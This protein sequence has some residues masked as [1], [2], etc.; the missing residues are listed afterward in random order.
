MTDNSYTRPHHYT[1]D[2]VIGKSIKPKITDRE[3]ALLLTKKAIWLYFWLIIFEGALRKWFLPFLA[4]PLLIVRDP[5]ALWI[6]YSSIKN[7][8]FKINGMTSAVWF[9]GVVAVLLAIPFG[10]GSV[11][12][13]LFGGR[14]LFL[15]FPLIFITANLFNKADVIEIGK[16]TLWTSI[17]MTMI[18]V[19]QFYSPQSAWI[20]KGIGGEEVEG[21]SG[22]MGF[23]RPP[24]T[25]SFTNGLAAYY[26]LLAAFVFYFWL[27]NRASVKKSLLIIATVCLIIA[28]PMSIS[29]TLFFSVLLSGAFTVGIAVRKPQMLVR[30]AIAVV[31]IIILLLVVGNL[32]FFQTGVAAFTDRFAS[33]SD[34]QESG[35]A[36]TLI[37]RVLGGM[38]GALSGTS[39]IPFFGYGIGMGT[40]VGASLLTGKVSFL[41]SEGEWGRVIGEMGILLGLAFI[42]IRVKLGIT[43]AL[44]SFKAIKRSNY[45]PW[46][47]LS[48]S[49]LNLLQGQWAQPSAL[50]FAV[51]ASGITMAA[52]KEN[53]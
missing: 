24:G 12:V 35:V 23:S 2:T 41:I 15:H 29:R 9:L 3:K 39:N 43:I 38:V 16:A 7:N 53:R 1:A 27:D 47:L 36:G 25:F 46:F 50:G 49:L 31:G 40:N 51:F 34:V 17:I 28:I 45:L 13:A 6:I 8:V 44:A 52:L 20:N 5:I 10:H 26:G 33:A 19:L 21:F 4:S 48:F 30:I 11:G 14:I 42:L 37:D 22:A 32:S 18:I